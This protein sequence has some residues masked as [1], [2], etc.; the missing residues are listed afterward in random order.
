M[1][2]QQIYD[3]VD[4]IKPNAFSDQTKTIWMN[5]IEGKVQTEVFLLNEAECREYAW[6]DDQNTVPLVEPPHSK[7]YGEYIIAR[8]DYANGEYDKYQNTM[9]MFN[10]FWGEFCR[11]FATRYRPADRWGKYN[12]L[13]E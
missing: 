5:E 4:E 2:L 3:Y 13:R 12:E 10:A 8:I 7:I 6:P 11:W 1:T 9:Q